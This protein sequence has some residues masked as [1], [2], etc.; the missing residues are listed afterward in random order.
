MSYDGEMAKVYGHNVNSS[1]PSWR[2]LCRRQA[3]GKHLSWKRDQTTNSTWLQGRHGTRYKGGI[4]MMRMGLYSS[5]LCSRWLTE[6]FKPAPRKQS[7]LEEAGAKMPWEHRV[8]KAVFPPPRCLGIW[9]S[10]VREQCCP[11][12]EGWDLGR[13]NWGKVQ[14]L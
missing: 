3:K 14:A 11:L 5:S 7:C 10:L 8:E 2:N 13:S 6:T 9:A 4:K 12:A 1:S